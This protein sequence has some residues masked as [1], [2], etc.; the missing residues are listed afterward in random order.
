MYTLHDAQKK[1][2]RLFFKRILTC[3]KILLSFLLYLSRT[4]IHRHRAANIRS[5]LS[6]FSELVQRKTAYQSNKTTILLQDAEKLEVASDLKGA[7]ILCQKAV[8]IDPLEPQTY[9]S[10]ADLYYL[11]GRQHDVVLRTQETG[12]KLMQEKSVTLGLN[13]FGVRIIN[14][15]DWGLNI[16]HIAA[17]DTLVKLRL[18]GQ[19]SPEKRVVF[20]PRGSVV[21]YCYLD[22]WKQYLD[23][24]YLDNQNYRLLTSLCS[25]ISEHHCIETKDGFIKLQSASNLAQVLWFSENRPPL[26]KLKEVDR[27]R[28]LKTL[29]HWAIPRGSWFVAIHVRESSQGAL[30][31]GP[32]ADIMTY[33]P[34]IETITSAGGYVIRMG[35]PGMKALP[36]IPNVIDY[37]NSEDKSD[38]MDV[39]LWAS[40]R[41]FIGTSSGPATVPPSFGTPIL[42]TNAC[43]IAIDHFVPDSLFLPKL[44]WSNDKNRFFTFKEMFDGPMAWS[45]SRIY[46]GVDFD[47]IDNTPEEIELA[48]VE[49]LDNLESPTL[50]RKE[51]SNLQQQFNELRKQYGDTTGQMTICETFIQ[52]HSDLLRP[53][54]A[55]I[56]Q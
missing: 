55:S 20:V 27:E 30:R 54:P 49:M 31:S 26:L 45:V 34:A 51:L 3:A 1:A 5:F 22:Y 16:G 36:P 39:F 56:L 25:S 6:E 21:N 19:L 35:H 43:A 44:F 29:E 46:D 10:L 9:F 53:W 42:H 2:L 12:L 50:K 4:L 7:L 47:L 52:K 37:A 32:N 41:F 13:L 48:V 18:L 28:G 24:I 8:E 15:E 11:Q 38:W 17:I 40:C 14:A 23:I 33:L